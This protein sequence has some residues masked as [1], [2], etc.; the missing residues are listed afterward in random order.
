MLCYAMPCHTTAHPPSR[1]SHLVPNTHRL[2]KVA[3]LRMIWQPA[4]RPS[5]LSMES[6]GPDLDF[7]Y[8]QSQ[9][10]LYFLRWCDSENELE[11]H[12]K[13]SR[14][15]DPSERSARRAIRRTSTSM[16]DNVCTAA[17]PGRHEEGLPIRRA[18]DHSELTRPRI[19]CDG[20]SAPSR[21]SRAHSRKAG[22]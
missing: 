8:L 5:T 2:P 10:V 15:S 9:A 3:A 4:Q 11:A 13:E 14:G 19:D 21:D 17:L 22:R 20:R 7:I 6:T 18:T 1:S 16:K 12:K